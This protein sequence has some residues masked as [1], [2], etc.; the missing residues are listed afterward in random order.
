MNFSDCG[1]RFG[2]LRQVFILFSD[3]TAYAAVSVEIS[4]VLVF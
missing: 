4:R 2:A 1:I 3:V